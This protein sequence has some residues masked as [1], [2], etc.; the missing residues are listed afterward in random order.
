MYRK[1]AVVLLTALPSL[2]GASAPG[3]HQN[4]L[5]TKQCLA[6]ATTYDW[7][8]IDDT[9]VVFEGLGKRHF[10][11][12]TATL[13]TELMRVGATIA[14]DAGPIN[15]LCGRFGEYL[16]V[17]RQRCRVASVTPITKD[18]YDRWRSGELEPA[19]AASKQ[20]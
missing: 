13:C 7:D 2:A 3:T 19:R 8:R 20:P 11:V 18:E 4:P 9:H 10:M 1:L 15:R 16:V 17:G 14:I 6:P 5:P 12:E